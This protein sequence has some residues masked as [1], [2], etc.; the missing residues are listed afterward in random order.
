MGLGIKQ[1]WIETEEL[2]DRLKR[3]RSLKH[4][5][6][7]TRLERRHYEQGSLKLNDLQNKLEKIGKQQPIA[8]LHLHVISSGGKNTVYYTTHDD[9]EIQVMFKRDYPYRSIYQI[10]KVFTAIAY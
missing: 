6:Q 2:R 10:Q 4:P 1:L 7:F 8:I 5:N 9:E 3:M